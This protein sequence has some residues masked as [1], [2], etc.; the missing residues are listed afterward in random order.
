MVNVC[1]L[2]ER[3]RCS[4]AAHDG[5]PATC[6]WGEVSDD[7]GV[8]RHNSEIGVSLYRGVGQG[9]PFSRYWTVS[10]CICHHMV[11]SL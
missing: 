10:K 1:A 2:T 3:Q 4:L 7:R 5:S 6:L 9:H 11:P 8:C